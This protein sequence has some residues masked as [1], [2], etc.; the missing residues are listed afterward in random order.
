MVQLVVLLVGLENAAS[1][2]VIRVII[3]WLVKPSPHGYKRLLCREV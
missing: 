3:N 2:V 1:V